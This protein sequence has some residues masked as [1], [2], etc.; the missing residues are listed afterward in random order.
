M[1][2]YQYTALDAQGKKRSGLI[3]A[4]GEKEA[5]EK[6][7]E[8]GVM[9]MTMTQKTAASSRENLKGE[10]LLNFTVQLSQLV[11]AG[12]PLYQSLLALEEQYR[13]ESIHRIILSLCE[14]IKAG[15]TLSQ[16]M[17]GYPVSF[18]KLY[19]SMI[20]AGESVGALNIVLDKL[21]LLLSKQ[22]KLK[23][24]IITA[25]IYPTILGGFSLL[26]IT[27][28][29]TF[30]VP[31]IEGIFEGRKLNSFTSAVLTA[32][33]VF[34]DYWWLYIPAF[35]GSIVLLFFKLRSPSGRVWMERTFLKV[36]LVR[37][38]IIQTCIARFCRTMGTLLQ[39]GL[40]MIDAMHISREVMRNVVLEEEIK[41]AEGKIIEGSSLS[42][43]LSK[44]KWVPVMVSRMLAVGEDSGT[45]TIMLNKIADMYE[46]NLEKT[47]DRLMAMAQPLILVFM[48]AIIGAILMAI[49][50]PLTDVSSFSM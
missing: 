12:I 23:R 44:S 6:L 4:H 30:V 21:S 18:N 5:K 28:L 47:L 20:A 33:H 41:K 39:G 45:T 13:N 15:S 11:N 9:I 35:V 46:D 1:P 16:A 34:R 49:L 2:L 22:M 8:Q 24:Q 29:M 37:T 32:S 14:Q 17:S 40:P 43:E 42:A 26:I 7:R 25:M 27:L 10:T 36:P 50:L 48:G 38:L 31:S 3:E 19:C